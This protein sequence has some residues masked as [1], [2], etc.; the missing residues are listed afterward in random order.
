MN[1]VSNRGRLMKPVRRNQD[2]TTLDKGE[3]TGMEDR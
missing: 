2:V 3:K 1:G